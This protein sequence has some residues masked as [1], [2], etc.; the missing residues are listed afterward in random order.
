MKKQRPEGATLVE[1]CKQW[2]YG[3]PATKKVLAQALG[4]TYGTARNWRYEARAEQ[5]QP[6]PIPALEPLP[7]TVPVRLDLGQEHKVVAV[8]N[9]THVPFHD[10]KILAAVE[11]FLGQNKP[12]VLIYNGD[13]IDFYQISKFDKDPARLH[14][15][16]ADVDAVVK[17]LDHH[18]TILPNT[19]R[20]FVVGNHERRLQSFLWSKA[21]ALSSLRCLTI[22]ALFGLPE[23][24][25]QLVD[26][27]QGIIIDGIFV[28]LHGDI[29]SIHSSY[30]S[31]RLM[32]KHGGCGMA[33][34]C[35]RAGSYY[36]RDR[37]G[38][39]GWWENGCLCSLNP[40]W[41]QNPNWTQ[42]FSLVHFKGDRFWVEQIPIVNGKFMYGGK[43]YG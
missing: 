2:D 24:G 30:T 22:D 3:S 7:S 17:M 29:A 4:V 33:G 13:T 41:V 28:V 12:D 6:E 26:Y 5:P 9:D 38:T 39:W 43:M 14:M 18:A 25:I 36:K 20:Y 10:P 23:R 1:F 16:Q 27:E 42:G 21:P 15:M 31:K 8:I 35:H 32:D 11:D 37:F 34:H 19:E 40:D